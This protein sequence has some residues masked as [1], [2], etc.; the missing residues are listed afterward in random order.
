[1][2]EERFESLQ[3]ALIEEKT[4][5]DK[6]LADLGLG[7]KEN[8]LEG[9][10]VEADEGFAD[11]AQAT[12][13]KSELL[14]QIEHLSSLHE[15]VEAALKR[16]EDGTYGRCENCGKDIAMERLEAVPWAA[17]CITCKQ[18]AEE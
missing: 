6:Q 7:K 14:A 3:K 1:V 4:S 15:E 17:L 9:V 10:D 16:L 12:A 8:G 13:G 5:L 2:T 11:T 18:Q